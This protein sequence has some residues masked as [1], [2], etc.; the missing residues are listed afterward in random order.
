[1][2]STD[3]MQ[4]YMIDSWLN[5]PFTVKFKNTNETLL[6]KTDA[7]FPFSIPVTH[8]ASQ[9]LS[10][11]TMWNLNM[12]VSP[13]PRQTWDEREAIWPTKMWRYRDVWRCSCETPKGSRKVLEDPA[14]IL[15]LRGLC[16]IIS[17]SWKVLED[18]ARI[19]SMQVPCRNL[20]DSGSIGFSLGKVA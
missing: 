19:L 13:H 7:T 11:P 12:W 17:G 9:V 2:Y 20:Q 3:I 6:S 10:V 8:S 5:V 16:R 18:T 15:S 4:G 1:M 14:K